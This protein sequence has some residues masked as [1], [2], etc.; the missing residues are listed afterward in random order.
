M[1]KVKHG[2][3]ARFLHE[4]APGE[5]RKR[6]LE[7]DK[8]EILNPDY[9]YDERMPGKSYDGQM[10]A[11]QIELVKMQSWVKETG[12]RVLCIFEGRDAA[13]KGGTIKR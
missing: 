8:D 6:V 9:P 1:T 13:G 11:L 12:Q 5:I 2:A 3:I 10:E 7:A 4:E